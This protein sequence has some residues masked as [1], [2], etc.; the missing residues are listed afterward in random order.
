MTAPVSLIG[1]PTDVGAS[2][3]GCRLAP[4][5]FRVAG[6][7]RALTGFG[8]D[9]R[10][11]GDLTGPENPQ[12]GAVA[13][14][15]H[16]AE[17]VAWNR[18]VHDATARELA[19]GRLP[20]LLGG[21]HSLAIGSISA[22]AAHCRTTGRA[23]RVIWID[24]HA[25][26]NT[27]ALTPSGNLH[28]MPVACLLGDGPA[29]LTALAGGPPALRPAQLRL[30]GIRSVDAGEQCYLRRRGL[31]VWRM[32][33]VRA[34]GMEATMAQVL[35]GIGAG[36]HHLHVSLDLDC[37]DPAL[38]PGVST[39]APDGLGAG[40]MRQCMDLLA[41]S[42]AVGSVDLVELNP[43]R[44]RNGQ[45]AQLAVDLLRR[46]SGSAWKWDLSLTHQA[47]AASKK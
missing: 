44:D 33:E 5:A 18:A 25:D 2:R 27:A 40:A 13:G 43:L 47:R 36:T 23:L 10:D 37:L 3:L 42:G 17:V 34:L 26:F 30:V 39:P 28:G 7:A 38:A 8:C 12:S 9:V 46:L 22:V 31:P 4:Q 14:Y 15:R 6:I 11:T 20:I 35:H 41:A 45:T 29:A 1:A 19:E 24:A 32:P 21:D 16:L